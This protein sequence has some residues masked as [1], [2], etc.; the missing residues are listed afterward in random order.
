MDPLPNNKRFRANPIEVII[1]TG[2][3]SLL[4]N[5][6]YELVYR[7]QPFQARMLQNMSSRAP[8]SIVLPTISPL[9]E[10]MTSCKEAVERRTQASKARFKGEICIPDTKTITVINTTNRYHATVFQQQKTFSTDYLHLDPGLNKIEIHFKKDM[11]TQVYTIEITSLE[12]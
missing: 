5:S 3:L 1:F 4:V 11:K 8:S 6:L 2:M 12:E 9:L 7:H 10:V